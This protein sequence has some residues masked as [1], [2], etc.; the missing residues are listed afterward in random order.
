MTHLDWLPSPFQRHYSYSLI[1]GMYADLF[2]EPAG[3][4]T[5]ETRTRIFDDEN[6]FVVVVAVVDDVVVVVVVALLAIV[7][8]F[9][10]ICNFL[11]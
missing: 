11:V 9:L 2:A 4:G 3:G 7:R 10:S 1:F 6:D 5:D 8:L